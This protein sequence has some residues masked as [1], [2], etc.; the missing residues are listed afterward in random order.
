M[1][2]VALIDERELKQL[3]SDR[4]RETE[5][6]SRLRDWLD[7]SAKTTTYKQW[8]HCLPAG[9][10]RQPVAIVA[11]FTVETIAPFFEVEAYLS[12]WCPATRYVQYA[13][14]QNVLLDP[15]LLGTDPLRGV[16]VLVDDSELLRASSRDVSAAVKHLEALVTAFRAR[17]PTPLF[18]GL[19]ESPPVTHAIAFGENWGRGRSSLLSE[20]RRGIAE[21]AE[22]VPDTHL[23]DARP[24]GGQ[25][26]DA[27]GFFATRS[28]FKHGA[29]PG[30][31]RSIARS[32]ACLFRPR[33]KVLVVD[34]D[35]TLWG[36]IVGEDGIDGLALGTE[37]PGSAFVE[38]QSQLQRLRETGI[39]LAICSKN[40]ETDGRSVFERRREMVLRWND[41]SAHRINWKDKASNLIETAEELGVGLDSLVFAD[42][43]PTECALVRSALPQIE[44]VELGQ[45]PSDFMNRVLRTQAF[46]TLHV[47]E[48]DRGRAQSYIAQAQRDSA[49]SRLTDLDG[50]L[51][52]CNL[53]LTIRPA[54]PK[55]VERI[56]QLIGKTNQF[57]FT[58]ERLS[59][60]R[61]QVL[62]TLGNALFSA[63]LSDRFGDYGLIGV[64]YLETAGEEM[65]ISNLVLSCRALGRRVEDAL[66]AFSRELAVAGGQ[67]RLRVT[68]IRGPRNQQVL[69]Y[70][71]KVGFSTTELDDA[72]VDCTLDLDA[73][74][75]AW[76][77]YVHM[78]YSDEETMA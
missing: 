2:N 17:V 34:L 65:W 36:G 1:P 63:S 30:V 53:R 69:E 68:C 32:M 39:L 49:Q 6:R 16:A 24:A 26:Y 15:F 42:D 28:V 47:S 9:S 35:N 54:E 62:A 31:A 10:V 52:D 56:H 7:S 41:F 5:A 76:P 11:S 58:L 59:K 8:L 33:R 3:L 51:A 67:R 55:A 44:V 20:L 14:W 78:D 71:E 13:Q 73:G 57:N 22:R 74:V 48:E 4:A 72:R 12:G 64:L 27:R 38:F 77:K 25:W 70:L 37:W 19:I 50:F 21:F 46:D 29:L 66:L 43:N 40:N 45:D 18:L 61:I 23:F 60:D 75:L